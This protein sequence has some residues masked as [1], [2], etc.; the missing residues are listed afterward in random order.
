MINKKLIPI[1]PLNGVIFYPKTNL[2][3]NIFEP[4]YLDMID[5][6]LKNDRVIGMI[7]TKENGDLYSVGCL[8][9]VSS[10]DETDGGSYIINL[11]GQNYFTLVNE[12]KS[13]KKFK[14]AEALINTDHKNMEN[15]LDLKKFKK[16][17]LV[18]KYRS[19]ISS[20]ETNIDLS[21]VDKIEPEILI[22]FIAMSFPFST[23]D[24]QF[25]LETYN[26]NDLSEKLINLFD[27]YMQ[28]QASNK[29]IN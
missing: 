9:K 22:K 7:Q 1:F 13:D 18:K 14:L 24:K 25:L 26:L 21:F 15:K 27:F 5:Y 23:T 6:A 2:P 12:I 11:F 20:K 28:N 17:I 3:L 10:F 19:L 4:R 8:G 16:N 29:K